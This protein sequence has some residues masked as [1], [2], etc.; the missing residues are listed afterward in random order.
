VSRKYED[1][2]K[3]F[4]GNFGN[5]SI[6]FLSKRYDDA[7]KPHAKS[8]LMSGEKELPVKSAFCHADDF[9]CFV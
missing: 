5:Q 1:L 3:G 4:L 6:I 7:E 9:L 2:T 8:S